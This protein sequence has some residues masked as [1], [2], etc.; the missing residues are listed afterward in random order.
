MG[1]APVLAQTGL[2]VAAQVGGSEWN[3]QVTEGVEQ[4]QW[5]H[6]PSNSLFLSDADVSDVAWEQALQVFVNAGVR[7]VVVIPLL[8]SSDQRL[9][10]RL[11]RL[12]GVD[13]PEPSVGLQRHVLLDVTDGLADVSTLAHAELARRIERLAGLARLEL[14][15]A[16]PRRAA[17]RPRRFYH[18]GEINVTATRERKEEFNTPMAVTVLDEVA[19]QERRPNNAAELFTGIPGLDVDGVGT[20]QQ[21]PVIRGISGQRVLLLEDGI[22][23]NNSRR[24]QESGEIPAMVDVSEINQVEVVRGASSVLYGSDAVG[25]VVNLITKKPTFPMSGT[26]FSGTVAYRYS[27]A[28]NQSKPMGSLAGHVGRLAFRVAGSYRDAEA[29]EAP[30]GRF[31]EVDLGDNARV[32]DTGVRDY[33]LSTHARYRF[34]QQHSASFKYERYSAQDAGFGF[35]DPELFGDGLP[36]VQLLF[37]TQDI[38]RYILGYDGEDLRTPISDDIDVLAYYQTN[39]RLF[40]TNVTSPLGPTAPPGAEVRVVSDNFTE[41]DTYGFRIEAKKTIG[42]RQGLT[43][44]IDLFRDRSHNTDTSTTTVVGFGPPSVSGRGTPRVPNATFR[45]LGAFLQGDLWLTQ[46][47]NVILGGRYQDVRA[48]TEDTPGI[49]EPPFNTTDR[50]FVGAANVLYRV[51]ENL[52]V[53]ASVGRAFRSPNLVERFFNGPSPEGRGQWIRNLELKPETSVNTEL[54]VKYRSQG[55]SFQGFVFRNS[56]KDGIRIEP[57]GNTVNE[58]TEY[59]NVNI[60]RLRFTGVELSGGVSVEAGGS[61][62]VG[63]THLAA[64]DLDHPDTPLGDS[65][66]NKLTAAARYVDPHGRFWAEYTVRH[67]GLQDD[68]EL[69]TSP[70]GEVIPAFTIHAIRGGVDVFQRNHLQVT[71]ANLTN[72]LYAEFPNASF[73]RPEPKRN[74][75]V[76]WTTEF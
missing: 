31:G 15:A 52:N 41:L 74:L 36:T 11:R 63:Y 49:N 4:V 61:L 27:T 70:V 21:R 42:V 32:N 44:G 73:F 1:A 14:L 17:E 25:G 6:G 69:G 23:L 35:V 24:R 67:N 9:V 71:I 46:R 57:T 13:D 75:I 64:K 8:G 68:V 20:N 38:D 12:A 54:G 30:A 50:T 19:L 59:Q 33:T 66:K 7:G 76:T 65:Y 51:L 48:K 60:D 43:Y 10:Q 5:P 34:S 45:S 3:R 22:R 26:D 56:V 62:T 2:L 58:V 40:T 16:M 47:L 37:P 28:D 39:D 55:V 72:E 29:Y 53:V 18:L